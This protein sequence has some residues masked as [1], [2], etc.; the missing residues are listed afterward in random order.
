MLQTTPTM[1]LLSETVKAADTQ[2]HVE[3]VAKG[4]AA[5]AAKIRAVFDRTPAHKHDEVVLAA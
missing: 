4:F 1:Y 2:E 5:I 3:V